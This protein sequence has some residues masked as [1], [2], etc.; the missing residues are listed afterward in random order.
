MY[1]YLLDDASGTLEDGVMVVRCGDDFTL[2]TL[3]CPEVAQAIRT[4]TSQKLG[5]PVGVRFV[6]GRGA[7]APAEQ[8]KL[9]ELIRQGSR[10][11]SFSV[12]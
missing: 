5:R 10:Y 12:K 8:D 11:D 4:V 1:W 2:E 9:E 7:E 3:N 6:L